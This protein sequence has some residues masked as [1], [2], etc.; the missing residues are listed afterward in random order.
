[1]CIISHEWCV[2]LLFYLLSYSLFPVRV[3]ELQQHR[4]VCKFSHM[5]IESCLSY[6]F[7]PGLQTL[8]CNC[9][10]APP[11]ADELLLLL[12]NLIRKTYQSVR[13]QRYQEQYRFTC[14]KH[15][16]FRTNR[17]RNLMIVSALILGLLTYLLIRMVIFTTERH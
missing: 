15:V 7:S 5:L 1:M 3:P 11:Q 6:P 17:N 13:F 4:L 8:G 14:F 10:D 12:D 9:L 16:M 2:L